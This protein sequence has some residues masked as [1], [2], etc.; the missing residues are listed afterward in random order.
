MKCCYAQE[1]Y[2]KK[3]GMTPDLR[4][5]EWNVA[6][7]C[8]FSTVLPLRSDAASGIAPTGHVGPAFAPIFT[9]CVEGERA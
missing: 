5:A 7:S 8:Q 1:H 9:G 6:L 3:T 4:H 2:E